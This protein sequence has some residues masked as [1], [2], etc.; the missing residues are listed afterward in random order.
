MGSPAAPYG[1]FRK[2]LRIIHHILSDLGRQKADDG[3]AYT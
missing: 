2:V 3:I 1:L